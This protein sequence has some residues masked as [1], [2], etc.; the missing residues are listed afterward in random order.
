VHDGW[1][2]RFDSTPCFNA[3]SCATNNPN[4]QF[5]SSSAPMAAHPDQVF[6]D[7]V[8]QR[9]VGSAGALTAGTFYVDTAAQRLYL[10]SD[11]RGHAVAASDLSEAMTLGSSGSVV[12]GL[13]V[14]RYGTALPRMGT[15]RLT[16]PH[17]TLEDV[18]VLD[19]A[20]TGIF[21]A[22]TDA[23]LHRVT[24]SRNGML[25]V[26]GNTADRSVVSGLRAEANNTEHFKMSPVSG[27]IKVA[28][29][30]D[31]TIRDSY[32]GHNEGPGIWF[33]SSVDGATVIRSDVIG[34]AGHGVSF[35]ISAR[36][37]FADD[38]VRD[39]GQD[40]FKINNS[41]DVQVW[42]STIIGNARTIEVVQDPRDGANPSEPGHDHRR[43][44][45]DPTMTWQAG[46]VSIGD[47]V[48][49]AARSS[50]NC[51]LCVEDYTQRRSA[52]QMGVTEDADLFVRTS[53][54]RWLVVWSA[55]KGNPAVFTSLA[56]YR[57]ASGQGAHSVES[58]S[59][60]NVGAVAPRPLPPAVAALLGVSRVPAVGARG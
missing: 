23:T 19:N 48:L 28:S 15:I 30:R 24:S 56:A 52:A 58:D 49:G 57:S 36:G 10:G 29:S 4:F 39:N 51:V 47:S 44:V 18:T 11:P 7:G 20:T 22:S 16:A 43:P 2:A 53:G 32:F 1:T 3:G 55:G 38:V 35:E 17:V 59:A 54:P 33:D 27:G 41:E 6:V 34:N 21:L 5:V 42:A 31:L 60:A 25:G 9:Q 40:G 12:R 37:V 13:G 50:A 46:R 8:A 45:P 14:R 26:G